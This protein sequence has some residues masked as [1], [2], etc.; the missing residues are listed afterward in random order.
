MYISDNP[1]VLA[2]NVKRTYRAD[3][4]R[5]I[6]RNPL[7]SSNQKVDRY[8]HALKGVNFVAEQGESIGVL[9]RNGSG[10]STLMRL[11]AGKEAPTDG[12]IFVSSAPTLLNVSAAL[13]PRLSGLENIRLGLL[14]QGLSPKDIPPLS[15]DIQDFADIGDAVNRPMNTYSS[16]MGAR[17][18]FAI[19]TSVKREVLLIDEA[20]ATG[21]AA[22]TKK[23]QD[24]MSGFL[25]DS[26]TI[27]LVSHAMATIKNICS[28]AIW[29][30]DGEIIADGPAPEVTQLYNKWTMRIGKG[31][32]QWADDLLNE[33][34]AA[35]KPPYIITVEETNEYFNSK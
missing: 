2:K 5:T 29:L 23:A 4:K 16:G 34:R 31:D 11:I 17:L 7:A 14:A 33:V 15:E 32:K 30:N 24:R 20:L 12:Q 18:K 27:F 21:D 6:F 28:R 26:G 19:S 3:N 25:S 35:Y 8:V 10:K 22:F 13:Q 9:G 1:T